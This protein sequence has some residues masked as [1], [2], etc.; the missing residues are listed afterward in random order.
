MKRYTYAIILLLVIL[1]ASV[2]FAAH[3]EL[4]ATDAETDGAN[5]FTE[6][7]GA[8]GVETFTISG[9]PYAIVASDAGDGVQIINLSNPSDI[10]ATDAE[11][12]EAN[13]FDE[14][15][16]ATNVAIFTITDKTYAI[17]A[18]YDDD[19]VQIIN[20]TDTSNIVATDSETHG[21]NGFD[22][23][24][25]ANDVATFTVD[26]KPYAIVT[27]YDLNGV[28]IINMT[29]P[30]DIQPLA[31]EFDGANGFEELGSANDVGTFT[32]GGFP[33]AIVAS[34]VDDGVQIIDLRD[35]AN[36]V[37]TDDA[38]DG[39]IFTELDGAAGVETFTVSGIVYA[40]VTSIDDNG[41]QIINVNDPTNISA[42][43][44]E[45][46][47][48][49]GFTVLN[50]AGGLATF[51]V[52][53][54]PYAIV[55]SAPDSG[56]QLVNLSDPSNITAGDTAING[57]DGFTE[58]ND[59]FNIHTFTS[60]NIIY[61][62]STNRGGDGVQITSLV[63]HVEDSASSD[64]GDCIPPTFGLNYNNFLL[65]TEGFSFNEVAIDVEYFHTPY[66]LITVITNQTNTLIVKVY[67]NN[68][69]NNIQLVQFG[70]GMPE[71]GSSLHDAQTLVEVWLDNTE[72]EKI[73]KW[74]NNNLVS[75]Q[76]VTTSIVDCGGTTQ[77]C[78]SVE[79]QYV[80]LD[81]PKY[82][83]MAINAVDFN[84]NTW[85][86]FM[87]EGVNVVGYSL[88]ELQTQQVS[89]SKGGPF[90]PQKSGSIT[91]SLTDYKNDTWIDKYGYIWSTNE[92]GPYLVDVISPPQ[93]TP[94]K[95]SPWS[96]IN[97]RSHSEFANY[98]KMIQEKATIIHEEIR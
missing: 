71:I 64:C 95:I 10:T 63:L 18:S 44:A 98:V 62:I 37:A 60:N 47:G 36:I 9:I 65:V 53:S 41:I 66:P 59:T 2:A 21:V 14:L 17:V 12:D 20:V 87:N 79:M 94:D 4:T 55:A 83:I 7:D 80:Y 15:N 72:I 8:Y 32:V 38:T 88:N 52:G 22:A 29:D 46:D 43:D 76:N 6:L 96:G 89:V 78:L 84:R 25:G 70:L 93:K 85:T 45:T 58:L 48:V 69:L 35:P 16:G 74:D 30:T 57:V 56:L 28:Q 5:G 11:T 19:G 68:G 24:D 73:I 26:D 61:A 34:E 92:Y 82:N 97:D 81:A 86:N 91:L 39:S 13:G 67:E 31:E 50:N 49:N 1:P 75:I 40:I 77:E 51:T 33:Y 3:I 42:V 27:S 23:L 90:Y 54:V